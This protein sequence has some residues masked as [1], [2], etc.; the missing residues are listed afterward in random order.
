MNWLTIERS[1][2]K[3][4]FIRLYSVVLFSLPSLRKCHIT[5]RRRTTRSSQV[6]RKVLMSS[7]VL[8]IV[9][10]TFFGGRNL[11]WRKEHG[12]RLFWNQERSNCSRRTS[13]FD[14]R[15]A[16]L[17]SSSNLLI[18]NIYKAILS[19][20]FQNIWQSMTV[21]F[22]NAR[23]VKSHTRQWINSHNHNMQTRKQDTIIIVLN[24][25]YC[26]IYISSIHLSED[27]ERLAAI[28]D[29]EMCLNMW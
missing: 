7:I 18:I 14:F 15:S 26:R 28:G 19:A 3:R 13:L 2:K 20:S 4:G 1:L 22:C 25:P 21:W 16:K 23:I 6:S 29:R 8:A 27:I 17:A 9:S 5:Y 24:M 10:A 11:C 12:W